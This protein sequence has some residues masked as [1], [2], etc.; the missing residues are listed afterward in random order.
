MDKALVEK[1]ISMRRDFT[2]AEI[3][4][5]LGVRLEDLNTAIEDYKSGK[6]EEVKKEARPRAKGKG[7]KKS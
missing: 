6:V 5:L 4:E 1:A 3:A 2:N 7:K